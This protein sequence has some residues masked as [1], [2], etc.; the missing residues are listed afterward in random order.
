MEGNL[1]LKTDRYGGEYVPIRSYHL[2]N[3]VALVEEIR[4]L[5]FHKDRGL[6]KVYLCLTFC[7]SDTIIGT[8]HFMYVIISIISANLA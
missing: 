4:R 2:Q 5:G 7:S 6:L 8:K 3:F 1:E